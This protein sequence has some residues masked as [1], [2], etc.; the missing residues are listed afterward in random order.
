MFSIIKKTI[1]LSLLVLLLG[2]SPFTFGN[3]LPIKKHMKDAKKINRERAP[4][5]AKLSGGRSLP[6]SYELITMENL[7]QLATS[8][9][10]LK[11]KIYL[12]NGIGLFND[13]LIDMSHTPIFSSTFK[14]NDYPTVR[15]K[16]DIKALKE[17]WLDLI[18]KDEVEY[19]YDEAVDLIEHSALKETNQNCLTRHFIESIAR[20]LLNMEEHRTKA[21]I[22]GLEDPKPIILSFLKLQIRTL[23]WAQSLDNRAFHIQ[24]ENIPLFCQDVPPIPYK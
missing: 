2:H 12:D 4:L 15:I 23:G 16:F 22:F 20:L 3:E 19:I 11:A 9:L 17:K 24:K 10:D 8:N 21:M 6:L 14:N 18:K 13:D 7:G 1:Q 5:Y